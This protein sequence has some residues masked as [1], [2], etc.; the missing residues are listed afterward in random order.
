[1]PGVHLFLL[2]F[3]LFVCFI[4]DLNHGR[5]YM[6]VHATGGRNT[7]PHCESIESRPLPSSPL[8]INY[9]DS[10]ITDTEAGMSYPE[11]KTTAIDLQNKLQLTS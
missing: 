10:L 11:V 4:H 1:M 3:C 8:R 6:A 7:A 5:W 9:S 2:V